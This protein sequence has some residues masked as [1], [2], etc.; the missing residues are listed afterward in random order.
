MT[1]LQSVIGKK[2]PM[3]TGLASSREQDAQAQTVPAPVAAVVP[4]AHAYVSP[5]SPAVLSTA[6]LPC[7]LARRALLLGRVL[8]LRAQRPHLPLLASR[9]PLLRCAL[10]LRPQRPRLL[11][12]AEQ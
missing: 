5:V 12:L 11:L 7:C 6:A 10:L 2:F 9:V 1:L 3:H 4:A 8:L